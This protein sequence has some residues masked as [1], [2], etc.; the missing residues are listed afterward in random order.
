MGLQKNVTDISAATA[1]GLGINT[2]TGF[3]R[4]IAPSQELPASSVS[5]GYLCQTDPAVAPTVQLDAA[6]SVFNGGNTYYRASFMLRLIKT[7]NEVG[8][9]PSTATI[10]DLKG[11]A[12]FVYRARGRVAYTAPSASAPD[13]S[14]YAPTIGGVCLYIDSTTGNYGSEGGFNHTESGNM[15]HSSSGSA[16]SPTGGTYMP[17]IP[18][19][20]WFRL[21]I[22]MD[23]TNKRF[24]LSINGHCHGFYSFGDTAAPSTSW[25]LTFPAWTGFLWHMCEMSSWGDTDPSNDTGMPVLYDDNNWKIW[26]IAPTFGTV[27]TAGSRNTGVVH[28]AYGTP[29]NA[30]LLS[31][32][33]SLNSGNRPKRERARWTTTS[34]SG[35]SC[36]FVYSGTP[37]VWND[38]GIFNVTTHIRLGSPASSSNGNTWTMRAG[39]SGVVGYSFNIDYTGGAYVM[40]DS[41]GNTLGS[42]AINELI[43]WVLSITRSGQVYS[44]IVNQSKDT[45]ATAA[46]S[47]PVSLAA[48]DAAPSSTFTLSG[49]FAATVSGDMAEMEAVEGYRTFAFALADSYTE[50]PCT[51]TE[52]VINVSTLTASPGG[53]VTE[54]TSG[55]TGTYLSTTASAGVPGVVRLARIT[56]TFAGVYALTGGCTATGTSINTNFG[57]YTFANAYRATLNQSSLLNIS[58]AQGDVNAHGFMTYPQGPN[59]PKM[60]IASSWGRSG[61]K[62]TDWYATNIV[63]NSLNYLYGATPV[64]IGGLVNDVGVASD[65]ATSITKANDLATAFAAIARYF[66]DRKGGFVW[67]RPSFPYYRPASSYPSSPLA[68]QWPMDCFYRSISTISTALANVQKQHPRGYRLVI[69]DAG[70]VDFE[71]GLHWGKEGSVPAFV[72]AGPSIAWAQGLSH[73]Q[74]ST[75]ENPGAQNL[76]TGKG[77]RTTVIVSP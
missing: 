63:S 55:A 35:V 26:G 74:N 33:Y 4:V 23:T 32:P 73:V 45:T 47:Y 3:T 18:L 37:M 42:W 66:L 58:D 22:L 56:G 71:D 57:T 25:T 2:L 76:T 44:T 77:K 61:K 49:Y 52:V 11:D 1:A 64:V 29:T 17:N 72:N 13:L 28:V 27:Q 68:G 36:P 15:F 40:T 60:T 34:N 12:G 5:T 16:T 75:V 14:R 38:D 31:I 24:W 46:Q 53:T 70:A 19:S 9:A 20:Q 39:F 6:G 62:L 54:A 21:D 59:Y 50:G 65:S 10:F 30:T 7:D 67:I 41:A 8:T 69:A 48:A 43:Q 51:G